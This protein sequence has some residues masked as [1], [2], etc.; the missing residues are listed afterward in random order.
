MNRDDFW[1]G[2]LLWVLGIVALT[3]VGSIVLDA[4]L[5][6]IECAAAIDAARGQT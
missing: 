1:L 2:F 5:R 3:L 4:V 6:S